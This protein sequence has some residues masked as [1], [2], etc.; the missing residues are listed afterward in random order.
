MILEVTGATLP[1]LLPATY[2]AQSYITRVTP[3]SL[4][5]RPG[6]RCTLRNPPFL[7]L[8][9][10]RGLLDPG[11]PFPSPFAFSSSPYFRAHFVGHITFSTRIFASLRFRKIRHLRKPSSVHDND[12]RKR[13]LNNNSLTFSPVL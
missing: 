4:H 3:T 7:L 10:H 9:I 8:S 13:P 2:S 1:F 11:I 5:P 12:I 6:N